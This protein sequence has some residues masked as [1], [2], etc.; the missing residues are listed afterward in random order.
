SGFL[1]NEVG[2]IVS[3][4]VGPNQVV[5][6]KWRKWTSLGSAFYAGAD[7]S[8]LHHPGGQERP[9]ELQQPLV[10]HSFRRL[11]HQ[12]VVID[13]IKK[14]FQVEIDRP[15]VARDDI[16]LRLSYRLMS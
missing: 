8:I 6:R 16:L 10:L 5:K 13:S 15:A 4:K 12:F 2:P 3:I 9:D 11:P 14:L 7:Q 1:I